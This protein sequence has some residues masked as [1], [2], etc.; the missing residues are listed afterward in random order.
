MIQHALP[1][2]AE[3]LLALQRLTYL[4]EAKLYNDWSIPPLTQT[5]ASLAEE[6]AASIILKAVRADHIVGSA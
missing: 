4:S 6:F 1:E 3:V 5:L 2:D